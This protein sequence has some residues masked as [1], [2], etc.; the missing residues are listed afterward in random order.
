MSVVI[1]I[2]NLKLHALLLLCLPTFLSHAETPNIFNRT[3]YA[4]AMFGFGSTTWEGLVPTKSNQNAAINMSTPISVTEGGRTWG[5]LAGYEFSRY[6]ALEANYMRFADA[7]IG[8]DEVSIFSFDHN[9]ARS[10]KTQTE[11]YSVMGKIMLVVP[12]TDLRVYSSAGIANLHR[13]DLLMDDW[14]ITPTF[15]FGVNYHFTEQI[16]G[17]IGGTYVA[18][19][20]ESQLNPTDTFHPFL[21]S[22][23]F[24][25]AYLF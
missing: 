16:M 24:R 19:F 10:F 1:V 15:G 12:N 7:T 3:V 17:E 23:A 6:F 8:F 5:F 13:Q 4:G 11:A 22:V 14:R 21:Y 2:K 25:L 20:G 18:G 9:G